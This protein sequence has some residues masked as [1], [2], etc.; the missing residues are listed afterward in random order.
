MHFSIIREHREFFRNHHWIECDDVVSSTELKKL[1]IEIP[2]ILDTRKQERLLQSKEKD[3]S[4]FTLGHDLWRASA[5]VKKTLL[6]RRMAGIASELTEKHPLRFGYDTLL[7]SISKPL[8]GEAYTSF[9]KTTPTLEEMSCIQGVIC[10]A[11]ICLSC[12]ETQND[13]VET[14]LFS[15]KPGNVVFVSPKWPLPLHDLYERP[16]C[17]YLLVVYAQSQ[18]VYLANHSDPHVHSFRQL[19]YDFGDRL[20][21]S[22]HPIV[23][24]AS[25]V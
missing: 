16:G 9:L 19:G 4:D 10:G 3:V 23:Y 5:P 14:P 13:D 18:A 1:S 8:I 22:L 7:P 11:I 20:K 2:L 21:D 6:S 12:S 25:P 17:S 15:S 24:E